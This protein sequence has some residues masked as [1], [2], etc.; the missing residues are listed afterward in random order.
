MMCL[1]ISVD[2]PSQTTLSHWE[3]RTISTTH[4]EGRT[5]LTKTD[6]FEGVEGLSKKSEKRDPGEGLDIPLEILFFEILS[7]HSSV[8]RRNW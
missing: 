1:T 6:R 5:I 7:A 3:G 4:W 2:N 8:C